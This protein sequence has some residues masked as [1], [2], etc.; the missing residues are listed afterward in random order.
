[1]THHEG[2]V[3][4][5]QGSLVLQLVREHLHLLLHLVEPL[6]APL[7]VALL[8]LLV[9]HL[10]LRVALGLGVLVR[11][12]QAER[13]SLVAVMPGARVGVQVAVVIT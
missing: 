10:L 12:P 11:A 1:M 3:L 5:P 6:L 13:G 2:V 9:L 7:P 4:S 8:G